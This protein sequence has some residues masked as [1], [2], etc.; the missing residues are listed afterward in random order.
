M[1]YHAVPSACLQVGQAKVVISTAGP[2]AELGTPVIDACVRLG[3]HYVEL[4]GGLS[5]LVL[6]T[7]G[8]EG[9]QQRQGQ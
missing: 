8:W 5:G 6:T 1:Q 4:S 9:M 2:Y 3:T 7:L